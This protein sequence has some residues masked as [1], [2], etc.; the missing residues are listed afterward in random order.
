MGLRQ[1]IVLAIFFGAVPEAFAAERQPG[2]FQRAS[3]TVVRYYVAK[4]GASAAEAWARSKGAS[5]AE[6]DAARA[7][8]RECQFGLRRAFRNEADLCC[9]LVPIRVDCCLGGFN[10]F[11]MPS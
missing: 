9:A 10:S 5:E 7:V 3:C 6:I 4:Y 8:S 11:H 1:L 2:V